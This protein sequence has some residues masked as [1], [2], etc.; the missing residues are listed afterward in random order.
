MIHCLHGF[1]G[2]GRDWDFLRDAGFEINAPDLLNQ[3]IDSMQGWAERF[4]RDCASGDAIIGYSM[5]GRLALHALVAAPSLFRSAV[6]VSAGLGVEGEEE[7]S[8]RR[9]RDA[10]WARRFESEEWTSVIRDWNA[11]P[12]FG[13]ASLVRRESD[14]DRVALAQALV[15]WSPAAH[16]SLEPMLGA[17]P[18]PVLWIAGQRDEKYVEVARRAVRLLPRGTLWICPDSAHRVPWEQP[19]RF[20][21]RLREDPNHRGTESTE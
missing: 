10:E 20:I 16:P 9:G 1:L 7:R 21:E 17:I 12:L 13:E 2:R 14:F 11:Q 19:G 15:R 4:V 6:I 8:L 3:P 5:G 18:V